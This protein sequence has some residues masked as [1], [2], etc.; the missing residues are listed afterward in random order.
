M[1]FPFGIDAHFGGINLKTIQEKKKILESKICSLYPKCINI[2][3]QKQP[4]VQNQET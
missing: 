2:G 1:F 4:N 3:N